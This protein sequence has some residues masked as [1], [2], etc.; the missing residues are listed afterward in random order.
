[1]SFAWQASIIGRTDRRFGARSVPER[2]LDTGYYLVRVKGVGT[3][4]GQVV[5]SAIGV[6]DAFCHVVNWWQA[7][8]AVGGDA[9]MLARVRCWSSASGIPVDTRLSVGATR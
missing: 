3:D 4:S 9:D 2:R 1:L 8:P 7:E 6:S 5:A